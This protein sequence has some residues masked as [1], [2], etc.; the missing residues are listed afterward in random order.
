[1]KFSNKKP[2]EECG[3]SRKNLKFYDGRW[4][5]YFCY[6]KIYTPLIFEDNIVKSTN[7]N[8]NFTQVQ[9]DAFKK[10]LKGLS[11]TKHEM[12]N[13]QYIRLLVLS[14]LKHVGLLK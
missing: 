5:C 4:L 9:W 8:L 11:K 2:C 6:P 7:V 12:K 3:K 13:S 10:R 1:M 14:D